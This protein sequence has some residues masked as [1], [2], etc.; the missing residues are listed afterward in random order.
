MVLSKK[1][2]RFNRVATNRVTGPFSKR[3]PGF[4]T[5]V[6]RGR[7]SGKTYRTPVN[8]FR[9]PGGFVVAL[10]YGPDADW[11]R[12]VLAADGCEIETRGRVVKATRPRL[13]HDE[14]R[15]GMPPG[16]RQILSVIGVTD[17]LALDRVS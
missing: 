15:S 14:R 10:T 5:I 9:T 4:G 7:K 1:V 12:N 6:H 17:F 3:L 11:V 8:V 16:V 13:V 2:A